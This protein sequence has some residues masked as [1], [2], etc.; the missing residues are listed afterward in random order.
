M[1]SDAP[2]FYTKPSTPISPIPHYPPTPSKFPVLQNQIDQ[3]FN[4]T[5]THIESA[6]GLPSTLNLSDNHKD[7]AINANPDA[8]DADADRETSDENSFSDPFEEPD[9]PKTNG[10]VATT[11]Q[12]SGGEV[13]DDYAMTFESDGEMGSNSQDVPNENMDQDTTTQSTPPPLSGSETVPSLNAADPPI[14]ATSENKNID[15][16][17]HNPTISHPTAPPADA[18]PVAAD[19]ESAPAPAPAPAMT[20]QSQAPSQPPMYESI[21]KGEIDIQQLLDNITANAELNASAAPTPTTAVAAVGSPKFPPGPS[22]LS[23]HSSL[24]PRP[25]VL[26]K[27][28]MHPAY[29]S[30]DDIRKYHAGP[31]YAGPPGT[32][33]RAPGMPP[34]SIVAAGAPGTHTDPRNVLPPPPPASF[35]APPPSLS[36]P[37]P[38]NLAPYPPHQ[39][40]P[41]QERP[42]E[43]EGEDEGEVQ[44]GPDVQK[45]Y[46]DFL[47]DE[48][49]YVSEGLWDRFPTGS[50]LF[51]GKKFISGD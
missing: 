36:A 29:A 3:V 41:T 14:N 39:R 46:D 8:A 7:F 49:M 51:I 24:P 20:E 28:S 34:M 16:L 10:T 6:A 45:L 37:P 31:S 32:S 48:R 33:Y 50:R 44:W 5:S 19:P 15:D 4:M 38:G 17:S 9:E 43:G 25:Q 12:A 35:N 22:A 47:A 1:T 13:D 27:P 26:Q 18:P 30:Q 23:S 11:I 40:V 42:I 21:A 2:E